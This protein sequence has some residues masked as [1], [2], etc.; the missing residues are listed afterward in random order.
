MIKE[1]EHYGL[2]RWLNS[3]FAEKR[4][5]AVQNVR[6]NFLS[7]EDGRKGFRAGMR[8][9]GANFKTTNE[10]AGMC[11]PLLKRWC[12]LLFFHSNHMFLYIYIYRLA[13]PYDKED[14][15]VWECMY[16]K[17]VGAPNKVFASFIFKC[18]MLNKYHCHREIS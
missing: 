10:W 16:R 7:K 5:G 13:N 15:A 2:G 18:L 9:A 1:W 12:V 6:K 14:W 11:K 4:G 3:E 17:L 8:P